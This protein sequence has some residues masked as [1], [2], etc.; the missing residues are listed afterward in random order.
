MTSDTQSLG[1]NTSRS[2]LHCH[3]PVAIYLILKVYFLLEKE[4]IQI[5]S[6]GQKIY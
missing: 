6:N 5:R 3:T 1:M 4:Q 2:K